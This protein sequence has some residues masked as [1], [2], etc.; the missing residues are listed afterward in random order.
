[1]YAQTLSRSAAAAIRTYVI[2]G[3]MS[4]K[5]LNTATFMERV[6]DMFD[7][8]NGTSPD[9][10]ER[11]AALTRE[12]MTYKIA[13]MRTDAAWMDDWRF[14]N[15]ITNKQTN[16]HTFHIGWQVSLH[17]MALLSQQLIN[18][19]FLFVPLRRLGQDHI[20]NMFCCV[21]GKNG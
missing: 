16:R 6:N 19:G 18:I 8:C 12:N 2:L 15:R 20:E 7:N 13:S 3:E 9:A 11:K 4:D 14:F 17:S 5:A 21:R 1:V 10:P